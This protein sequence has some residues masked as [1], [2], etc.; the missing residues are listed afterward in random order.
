MARENY[1]KYEERAPE[2]H[3]F[4][5]AYVAEH[6]YSPT[7]REIQD[8]IGLG[9]ASSTHFVIK[10]MLREG[11]LVGRAATPRTLRVGHATL[12]AKGETL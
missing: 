9:S 2:I 6:G 7:V 10:R 11:L 3:R 4:V 1:R 8:H 12:P 5:A